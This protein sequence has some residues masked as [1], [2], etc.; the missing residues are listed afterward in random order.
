MSEQIEPKTETKP[1]P[2]TQAEKLKKR[3]ERLKQDHK[4]FVSLTN[5]RKK[6]KSELAEIR[7]RLNQIRLRTMSRTLKQD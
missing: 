7:K 6:I 3:L 2:L 5:R 4:D 1:Q